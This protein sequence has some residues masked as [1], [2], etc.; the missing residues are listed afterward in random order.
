MFVITNYLPQSYS[1]V[2]ALRYL[3]KGC[4]CDQLRGALRQHLN[5]HSHPGRYFAAFCTCLLPQ[6]FFIFIEGEN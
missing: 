3:E 1:K 6:L 2:H 5:I 4:K